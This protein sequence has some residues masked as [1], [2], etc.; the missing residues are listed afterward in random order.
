MDILWVEEHRIPTEIN[1]S[2]SIVVVTAET[3]SDEDWCDLMVWL[4]ESPFLIYAT[5]DIFKSVFSPL[6]N[7]VRMNVD[8]ARWP[9]LVVPTA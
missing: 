5:F 4:E 2:A 1:W 7:I 6:R 8:G 3:W 9:H